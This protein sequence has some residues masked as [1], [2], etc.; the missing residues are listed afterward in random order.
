[1]D[2]NLLSARELKAKVVNETA[3]LKKEIYYECEKIISQLE[4]E[5]KS[6][7][8]YVRITYNQDNVNIVKLTNI[9]TKLK[10]L[11]YIIEYSEI[12]KR[13]GVDEM[14]YYYVLT[15]RV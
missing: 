5:L 4:K 13:T 9:V 3:V 14:T 1:M 15:V 6:G 12:N 8:S 2:E 11:G 7:N 10:K